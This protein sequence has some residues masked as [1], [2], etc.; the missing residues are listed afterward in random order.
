M[1]RKTRKSRTVKSV[2][3]LPVKTVAAKMAESVKAGFTSV[4]HGASGGTKTGG[5]DKPKYLEVKMEQ[6]LIS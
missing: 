2:R 1:S 5:G 3:G 6:T 4:E